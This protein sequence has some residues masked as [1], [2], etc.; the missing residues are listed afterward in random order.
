M[1]RFGERGFSLAEWLLAVLIGSLIL[2]S[3]LLLLQVQLQHLTRLRVP[4]SL[5]QEAVW[6][7]TRWQHGVLLA[8]QG[9]VAAL[10][11]PEPGLRAWWPA[12]GRGAGTPRSDQLLLQRVL[13]QAASDCEGTLV[14][15]GRVLVERYHV[16]ADSSS[17]QLVLACDGGS[18]GDGLCQR[19]GDAGIALASGIRSLQVLYAV[20]AA[21]EAPGSLRWVDATTLQAQNETGVRGIRIGLLL[22]APESAGGQR[23]SGAWFGHVLE[24]GPGHAGHWQMTWELPHG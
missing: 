19:L 10:G 18:C 7:L 9:G 5:Q 13:A 16:R 17:S 24:A 1:R 3:A 14:A 4:Q 20:P 12:D 2:A 8:G 21:G 15:A 6:L 22:S 23:V 11:W